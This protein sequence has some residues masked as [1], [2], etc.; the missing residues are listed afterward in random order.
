MRA[1]ARRGR[2]RRST[3]RSRA[4]A[5]A[6]SPPSRRRAGAPQR[7]AA[8]WA[9]TEQG[10]VTAVKAGE[11]DGVTLHHD[12]VVRDYE[13]V[14]AWAARGGARA[15]ARASSRRAPPTRRIRARSTWSSST[16]TRGRPVQA[17]EGRLLSRAQRRAARSAARSSA[18]I[19]GLPANGSVG[20]RACMTS[21]SRVCTLRQR[22][23]VAVDVEAVA[24]RSRRRRSWRRRRR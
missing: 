19:S 17:R 24:R 14:P 3:S 23:R 16:P 20:L 4:T 12:F 15:D 2:R 7:L 18:P 5:T 11:N 1:A 9:V 6:S 13:P 8:Y 22:L 10:H 21:S